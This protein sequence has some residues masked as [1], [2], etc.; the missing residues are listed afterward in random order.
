MRI[1]FSNVS[2]TINDYIEVEDASIQNIRIVEI[3]QLI[4]SKLQKQ[5]ADVTLIYK[6]YK[7]DDNKR[8]T[9]IEFKPENRFLVVVKQPKQPK[10]FGQPEQN[11]QEIQKIEPPTIL[12]E[13]E[14]ESGLGFFSDPSIMRMLFQQ[15]P[16]KEFFDKHPEIA[17]ILNDPKELKEMTKLMRNP[18]LMRQ[19]LRNNDSAMNQIENIPG[20]HNELIKLTS[21]LDP[22]EE[23][24]KPGVSYDPDVT[25]DK[26]QMEKPLDEP[27]NLFEDKQPN[28]WAGL[29]NSYGSS[30]FTQPSVFPSFSRPPQPVSNQL[31]PRERFAEQL[32]LLQEMG[33]E[34]EERDLDALIR[35]NGDLAGAVDILT[36]S[37]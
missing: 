23:M 19:F 3:R 20:G 26:F 8:L 12:M 30:P 14:P 28:P 25:N 33:F 22:L 15:G 2:N 37:A 31:P 6:G 21:G 5:I 35:S 4:C 11:K 18:E 1:Q 17:D 24:M 32:R 36:N 16:Y 13:E 7:I 10:S 27:F 9:E 29:S 34:N